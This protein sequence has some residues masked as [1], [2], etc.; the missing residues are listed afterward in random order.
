[1]P[2]NCCMVCPKAFVPGQVLFS[3]YPTTLSKI[4]QNYPGMSF[5]FYAGDTQLCIHLTHKNVAQ[6]FSNIKNW[7]SVS[8]LK[9]N[10]NITE[11][12]MLGSKTVCANVNEFFPVI[13]LGSLFSPTEAVR[14]LGVWYDSDFSFSCHDRNTCKVFFHI[15][16]LKWLRLYLACD[17]ALL[18][19]DALVGTSA[20][21]CLEVSLLFIFA[22]SSVSRTFFLKL[23]P[24]LPNTHTSLLS[25]RLFVGCLSNIALFSRWP[26]CCTSSYKVVTLNSLNLP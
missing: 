2:K 20:I 5:H 1:M 17:A 15:R 19:A 25:E 7:L 12:I 22:D 10:P 8:K 18:A 3:L 9:L 23:L 4:N 16:D 21:L 26:Y 14:N 6:T 13:K 24:I 11:F